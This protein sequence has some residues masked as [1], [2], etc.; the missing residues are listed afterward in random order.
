[1]GLVVDKSYH[2]HG[3]V[4]NLEKSLVDLTEESVKREKCKQVKFSISK[5]PC[6]FYSSM[7]ISDMG[8][9]FHVID[10]KVILPPYVSFLCKWTLFLVISERELGNEAITSKPSC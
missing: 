7:V 4:V 8:C 6:G 3:L 10:R 1:M 5:K 9:S 2:Q